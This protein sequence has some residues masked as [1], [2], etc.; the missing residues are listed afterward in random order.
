MNLPYVGNIMKE[1]IQSHDSV[2]YMIIVCILLSCR[3]LKNEVNELC[4]PFL[5]FS[6]SKVERMINIPLSLLSEKRFPTAGNEKTMYVHKYHRILK[7]N[8]RNM[9]LWIGDKILNKNKQVGPNFFSQSYVFNVTPFWSKLLSNY[10]SSPRVPKWQS[11]PQ[12]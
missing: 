10:H 3:T 2:K 9:L 12:V 4:I 8:R 5:L 11:E 7:G 6:S 1:S